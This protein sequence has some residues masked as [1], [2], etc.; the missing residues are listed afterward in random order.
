MW[1]FYISQNCCQEQ[2]I[3]IVLSSPSINLSVVFCQ[4]FLHEGDNRFLWSNNKNLQER[5]FLCLNNRQ[6]GLPICCQMGDQLFPCAVLISPSDITQITFIIYSPP[7]PPTIYHT[8]LSIKLSD[9]LLK[10]SQLMIFLYLFPHH[11]SLTCTSY[12]MQARCDFNF[13]SQYF[14]VD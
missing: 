3:D 14:N 9:T 10:A 2:P 1:K 5:Y 11:T 7:T 12:L 8:Y 4:S 13:I 6:C